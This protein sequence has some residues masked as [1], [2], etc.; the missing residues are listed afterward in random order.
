MTAL[1]ALAGTAGP[2][3]A[4]AWGDGAAAAGDALAIDF[5]A[6]LFAFG[7][8][9]QEAMAPLDA[10]AAPETV[11]AGEPVSAEAATPV[12]AQA[13]W[14][15][16]LQAL[17]LPP[18]A[19]P[20]APAAAQAQPV[21]A[22][23]AAMAATTAT[24][25]AAAATTATV[26]AATTA[27]AT[28]A[29]T[30]A[31]AATTSTTTSARASVPRIAGDALAPGSTQAVPV[32]GGPLA[33]ERVAPP[34]ATL[35]REEAL[36]REAAPPGEATPD[37][38][39]ARP[40]G[41]L[42]GAVPTD[43][44]PPPGTLGTIDATIAVAEHAVPVVSGAPL[45]R[46]GPAPGA[47]LPREAAADKAAPQSASQ[48]IQAV[49][50]AA[51]A[52]PAA[53]AHVPQAKQDAMPRDAAPA[54]AHPAFTLA[55]TYAAAPA[56]GA[57]TAAAPMLVAIA[58]PFASPAF[59]GA[60]SAQLSVLARDGVQQAELRLN[61]PEMG[62]IAVRIEVTGVQATV[63]FAAD[64]AATRQV[65]E[66]SLPELAGALRDAGLTL[67]GGG[68]SEQPQ[69]GRRDAGDAAATPRRDDGRDEGAADASAAPLPAARRVRGVVDLVA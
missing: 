60:L 62:P 33:S 30:V 28:A 68:V 45:A 36:P 12:Q 56:A 41:A 43:A 21:A 25:T 50:E 49:I 29:A 18:P 69:R 5:A 7:A 16:D 38:A 26:A 66:A 8:A 35:P 48:T 32:A 44:T 47:R 53:H 54:A 20:W 51:S 24:T 17:P 59:A 37:P 2:A 34:R 57:A 15:A 39:A 3:A 23:T 10:A 55:D 6:L 52:V 65:L 14:P 40:A 11:C 42:H 4:P 31:T 46:E 67:V 19:V 63:Y 58:T 64:A 1:A 13:L 9:P 61:P 27:T 22:A